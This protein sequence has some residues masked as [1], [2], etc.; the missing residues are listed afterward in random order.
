MEWV[1]M[2]AIEEVPLGTMKGFAAKGVAILVANIEGSFYAIDAIC[3][4][5]SGYLP[6]GAPHGKDRRVPGAQGA[7]RRDH[8]EAA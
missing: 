2:G 6:Q 7:V 4:H 1:E 5:T 8:G 3:S